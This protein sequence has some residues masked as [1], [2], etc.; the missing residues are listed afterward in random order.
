MNVFSSDGN[1]IVGVLGSVVGNIG[2]NNFRLGNDGVLEFD[3]VEEVNDVDYDSFEPVLDMTNEAT[4]DGSAPQRIFV[5]ELGNQV[6]EKNLVFGG[7]S[8]EVTEYE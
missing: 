1:R 2:I 7:E 4:G 3:G 6:F 5:D 8:N